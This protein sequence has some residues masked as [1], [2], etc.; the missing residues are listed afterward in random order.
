[1]NKIFLLSFCFIAITQVFSDDIFAKKDYE[2]DGLFLRIAL[3]SDW[4]KTINEWN[5]PSFD[6]TPKIE[7]KDIYHHGE[8]MIPFIVYCTNALD[9]EGKALITYDVKIIKPN[10]DIYVDIKDLIVIDGEPPSGFGMF[11]QPLGLKIENDDPNG[12]Y[13]IE[14]M[15]FDHIKEIKVPFSLGFTVNCD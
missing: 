15:I 12:N 6:D 10:G 4:E 9:K 8:L 7:T 14:I 2:N 1:M 13:L 5:N 3:I 11:Q